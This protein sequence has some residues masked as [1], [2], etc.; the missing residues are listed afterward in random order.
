MKYE[1][2]TQKCQQ[3]YRGQTFVEMGH[4]YVIYHNQVYKF[5]IFKL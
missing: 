5:P 1:H 3:A 4:I 2:E